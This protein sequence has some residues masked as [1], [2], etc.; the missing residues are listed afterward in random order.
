MARITCYQITANEKGQTVTVLACFNAVGD[1]VPLLFVLKGKR[2]QP[3]WCVG[4]QPNSLVHVSDNGWINAQLFTEWGNKFVSFLPKDDNRPHLV[5]FDGHSS[6][7]Y[8]IPFLTLMKEHNVPPFA[9]PPHCSHTGMKMVGIRQR[10]LGVLLFELFCGVWNKSATVEIAKSGFHATGL[11]PVNRCAIPEVAL[12]PSL[13]TERP[14]MLNA[15]VIAD[16]ELPYNQPVAQI[17]TQ[18]MPDN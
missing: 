5:L 12:A 13:T 9:F 6:H 15:N 17:I 16:G 10:N 1:Y 11:F 8:N 14:D 4:S 7:I 2:L 18:P 3:S